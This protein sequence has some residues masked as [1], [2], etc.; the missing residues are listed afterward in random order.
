MLLF[1]LIIVIS[2]YFLRK[3]G[4]VDHM[5]YK[6]IS[7]NFTHNIPGDTD[8]IYTQVPPQVSKIYNIDFDSPL[9]RYKLNNIKSKYNISYYDDSSFNVDFDMVKQ[10]SNNVL[11]YFKAYTYCDLSNNLPSCTYTTCGIPIKEHNQSVSKLMNDKKLVSK[12]TTV[13]KLSNERTSNSNNYN[14][15]NKNSIDYLYSIRNI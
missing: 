8:C 14:L 6:D 4:L 5:K 11:P 13:D 9:N 2:I 1:I 15:Y 3:E 12:K 10:E 7:D